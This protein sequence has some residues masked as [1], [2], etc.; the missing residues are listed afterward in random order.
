M[1][2]QQIVRTL[3]EVQESM[4]PDDGEA[5]L[6]REEILNRMIRERTFESAFGIVEEYAVSVAERLGEQNATS[7]SLQARRALDYI[8]RNYQDPDL[9]LNSV[10]SY[11][12]ISMSHFSTIF[13]EE[14]GSTFMEVLTGMRM[15][16][17]KE[18]LENTTL[19]NYEIA[20]RVGFS[21]PHYFGVAFKKTTGK[22]PTEYAKERR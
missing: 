13:K 1:Y 9:S 14:T 10:C 3:G 7:G 16:K 20:G 5:R 8:S 12:G 19:K 18:L 17:A 4:L 2:L 21:D 15:E 22:T 6:E 11:L